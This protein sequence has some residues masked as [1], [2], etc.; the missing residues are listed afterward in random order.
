MGSIDRVVK[1]LVSCDS[2]WDA[3]LSKHSFP[4]SCWTSAV[5]SDAYDVKHAPAT[6]EVALCRS[7]RPIIISNPELATIASME[8]A[9][10][11]KDLYD[12]N[13]N[14][15][16]RS[17]WKRNAVRP[18]VTI[19]TCALKALCTWLPPAIR[20]S[21]WLT[22][23]WPAMMLLP[24]A[25]AKVAT[26]VPTRSLPL[27]TAPKKASSNDSNRSLE[28]LMV[29]KLASRMVPYISEKMVHAPRE[30]DRYPEAKIRIRSFLD[31]FL[32]Y[33]K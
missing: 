30:T 25:D 3:T 17:S 5:H 20:T 10:Q 27:H 23:A 33:I 11:E 1:A 12:N 2:V 16:A 15:G 7:L 22:A 13:Q 6:A 19:V 21:I 31:H 4:P 28:S 18:L 14:R 8:S 32:F 26:A 29:P 9:P 24:M